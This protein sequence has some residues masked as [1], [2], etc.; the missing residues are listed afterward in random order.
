MIVRIDRE[1]DP[2]TAGADLVAHLE[3]L[4]VPPSENAPAGGD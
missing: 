4:G 1:V 2:R 3:A